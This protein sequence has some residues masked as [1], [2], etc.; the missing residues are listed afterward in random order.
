MPTL[1][2]AYVGDNRRDHIAIK[3]A[4]FPFTRFKGVDALLGP[5][6]KSTG[7]VM[8]IDTDFG[9]AFAKAQLGAGQ[10]L[11]TTGTV[12]ISVK[13]QDKSAMAQLGRQLVGIGFRI[14]ATGGTA[15]A[16]SDVG[17]SVELVN[18][19]KEGRP[20]I[21]DIMKTGEVHLVFSTSDGA[22]DIADSKS[23]RA[24]AVNN[25]IP[26]YTTVAGARATVLAILA[27]HADTLEVAPLQSYFE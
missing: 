22:V 18:K 24:T 21:V 8:G 9:R 17:I 12:F 13:N 23:L 1:L 16:F 10:A 5:E 3:E 26:Y 15:K 7:E 25:R 14:L 19:V 6:M 27:M 4:V 11:P 2:A 20:H